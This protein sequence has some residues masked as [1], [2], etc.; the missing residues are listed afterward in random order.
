MKKIWENKRR[1]GIYLYNQYEFSKYE[2]IEFDLNNID[3]KLKT[4]RMFKGM[5]FIFEQV[6]TSNVTGKPYLPIFE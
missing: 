6:D 4:N 1:N 3:E 2:K 5:E